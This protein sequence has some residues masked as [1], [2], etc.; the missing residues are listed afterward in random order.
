M[1]ASK[2]PLWLIDCG[3]VSERTR[4]V[5]SGSFS[6]GHVYPFAFWG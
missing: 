3:R 4:G 6:D 2:A 5:I 1:K